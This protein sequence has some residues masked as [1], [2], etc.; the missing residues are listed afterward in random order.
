MRDFIFTT[1]LHKRFA[2][3]DTLLLL[4]SGTAIL[5]VFRDQILYLLLARGRYR[6]LTLLTLISAVV[7]LVVSYVMMLRIGVA[8]A[9][10]GVLSGEAVNVT[11]LLL[12]S[13]T[14]VRRAD[15]EP[16]G[17]AAP[18]TGEPPT[19]DEPG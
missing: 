7:S 17:G 1:L 15:R 12:M 8:G 11:G 18:A 19:G 13:L 16:L 14:E 4:W 5:M 3:R 9:P 6:S 10:V 2:Q